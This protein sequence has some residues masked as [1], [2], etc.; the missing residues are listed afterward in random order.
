MTRWTLAAGIHAAICD[1]DLVVLD[2]RSG[3]YF[4]LPTAGAA[5]AIDPS[6]A[7]IDIK[8]PGL[9]RVLRQAGLVTPLSVSRAPRPVASRPLRDLAARMPA[10]VT[11]RD[12]ASFARTVL[13]AAPRYYG[14]PFAQVVRRRRPSTRPNPLNEEALVARALAFR[15][16]L[17]WA[18]F[19]GVCLYRSHLLLHHLHA[20]GLDASWVIGVQTWPFAAH[21]WLQAGDL[22][23]DD[24]VDNVSTYTPILVT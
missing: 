1:Q 24:T 14:R 11:W 4:C 17:P 16:L 2:A 19:Q 7:H 18:P 20:V 13:R 5:G 22:V 15:Q 23:L 10:S 12:R 6:Q 21:C 3:A 9:E 8:D